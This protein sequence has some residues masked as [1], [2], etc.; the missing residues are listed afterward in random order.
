MLC[1]NTRY[2]DDLIIIFGNRREYKNSRDQ[3]QFYV[4][5]F[6]FVAERIFLHVRI[7]KIHHQLV[8]VTQSLSRLQI[9]NPKIFYLLIRKRKIKRHPVTGRFE[10]HVQI[11]AQFA[12]LLPETLGSIRQLF[13][14]Q[15]TPKLIITSPRRTRRA[16]LH[17]SNFI[18]SVQTYPLHCFPSINQVSTYEHAHF[19]GVFF[20][21][22]ILS[23]FAKLSLPRYCNVT[24]KQCT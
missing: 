11:Q 3:L 20:L 2:S 14:E 21:G 8:S 13:A 19:S 5:V 18:P 23:R 17:Y 12:E 7:S 22:Q 15:L 6:I 24:Y 10:N 9:D 16:T 1:S 4:Q